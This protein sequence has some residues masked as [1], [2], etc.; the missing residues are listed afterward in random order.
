MKNAT[1]NATPFYDAMIAKYEEHITIFSPND[2]GKYPVNK[3][4]LETAIGQLQEWKDAKY[5]ATT[6][7]VTGTC[8]ISARDWRI[9]SGNEFA[10]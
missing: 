6:K 8:G 2:F 4:A 3:E 1:P 10:L 5:R 9:H 7:P